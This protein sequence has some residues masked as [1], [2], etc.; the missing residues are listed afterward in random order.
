[1]RDA[2][3]PCNVRGLT[4]S[5]WHHGGMTESTA[6][7]LLLALERRPQGAAP[8]RDV[9]LPAQAAALIQKIADDLLRLHPGIDALDLAAAAILFDPAQLLRPGW[10]VDAALAE[11]VSRAPGSAGADGGRLLAFGGDAD[12]Y[13]TP[14]LTPDPGLG[15]GPLLLLPLR[16]SG[17]TDVVATFA[18]RLE[19]QLF[20]HGMAGAATALLAQDA[21]GIELEHAR[22]LTRHDLCAMTAMQYEHA[23]IGAL[24]PLIESALLGPGVDD[25]LDADDLP[26]LRR[27]GGVLWLGDLADA[28]LR[29]RL[30]RVFD[31]ERLLE[32]ALRRWP[33]RV[34]Q[35]EAVLA[36]HGLNPQRMPLDRG[37]S[38]EAISL[39]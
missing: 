28:D 13:P 39:A 11:L 20:D 5:A 34:A 22:Y 24:W 32:A 26:P 3:W 4:R 23:G 17:D 21:F 33:S 8:A 19:A 31:D 7:P 16:L 6:I 2:S 37:Q 1:M 27:I 29:P 9:L 30:A 10:P 15:Q 38:L 14:A 12:T 36:A 18:D 25:S 35:V